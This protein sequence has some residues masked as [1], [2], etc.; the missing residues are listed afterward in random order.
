M[1]KHNKAAKDIIAKMNKL[2]LKSASDAE[3]YLAMTLDKLAYESHSEG[4]K[5]GRKWSRALC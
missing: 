4:Y 3:N 5:K 2:A 1:T